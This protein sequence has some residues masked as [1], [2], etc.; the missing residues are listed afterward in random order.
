MIQDMDSDQTQHSPHFRYH[1]PPITNNHYLLPLPGSKYAPRTLTFKRRPQ[2]LAH[3]LKVYNHICSHY[4]I[5]DEEEKCRGIVTYCTSKVARMIEKLPSFHNGDFTELTNDLYY[6]LD[7]DSDTYSLSGVHSFARKW[8]KR[9]IDS[10]DQFKRYHRKYLELVGKAIGSHNMTD[11]DCNQYFWEGIHHSLRKRI[12]DRMLVKDPDL[13]VS[14]PFR[15]S[16]VVKAAGSLLTH[17][18]FD[19]HLLSKT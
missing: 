17:K 5:T 4:D 19:Q 8:R 3:F 15:M 14:I 12:E 11:G 7:D 18:R 16:H 6:F 10:L 13:N 1:L 2:E 9:R